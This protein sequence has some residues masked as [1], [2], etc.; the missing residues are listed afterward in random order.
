VIRKE[1]LVSSKITRPSESTI[2]HKD[3]RGAGYMPRTHLGGS[4]N[5][6][7]QMPELSQEVLCM[8][9]SKDVDDTLLLEVQAANTSTVALSITLP[10]V[11]MAPTT[12]PLKVRPVGMLLATVPVISMT[13]LKIAETVA[14]AL[15]A[16]FVANAAAAPSA[17]FS[18]FMFTMRETIPDILLG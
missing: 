11:N 3:P 18:F 7:H 14:T 17:L 13:P 9:S 16:V 8:R 12:A 10:A 4:T 15:D 1:E 6:E 2:A 5:A